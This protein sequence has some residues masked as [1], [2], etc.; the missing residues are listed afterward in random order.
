MF[1]TAYGTEEY[2]HY[3]QKVENFDVKNFFG[4][5]PV[6]ESPDILEY[7]SEDTA[8]IHIIGAL[9]RYAPHPIIK[10]FFGGTG[11]DEIIS[12]VDRA[13]DSGVKNI[14]LFIDTPGGA[15]AGCQLA[16]DRLM[17]ARDKGIHIQAVNKG[18]M[19][20]A[21]YYLAS[22]ANEI[23]SESPDFMTG[24]IGTII[25]TYSFREAMEREGIKEIIIRS[26]NAPNKGHPID[27]QE[28]RNQA[29][30]HVNTY[31]RFFLNAVARGREMHVADVI[32]KFGGGLMFV[33]EDPDS[34]K[35]DAISIGMIDGIVGKK[36]DKKKYN[37]E[38]FLQEPARISR[39]ENITGGKVMNSL[40]DVFAA[41]PALKYEHDAAIEKARSEGYAKAQEETKTRVEAASKILESDAYG[42]HV[43]SVAAKVV[44]GTSDIS[45]LDSVVAVADMMAEQS[46]SEDAQGETIEN[47]DTKNEPVNPGN[48]DEKPKSADEFL[49]R[50][51]AGKGG[52]K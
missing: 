27:T 25:Y 46:N 28:G 14:K 16:Y 8:I 40:S 47:G 15:S 7:E 18:K 26:I 33:A 3:L 5:V 49:E 29:E 11:Y 52:K 39:N 43:K 9:S 22:S 23:L 38:L 21:G 24:S 31:E 36:D 50:I 6:S 17:Q 13:Q 20:S 51:K 30:N 1:Y 12:A 19:F 42:K 32:N 41:H 10:Q 44:A 48:T 45:A 37:N 34:D 4:D 2:I 35:P